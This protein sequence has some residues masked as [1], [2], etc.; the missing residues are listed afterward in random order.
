MTPRNAMA[1]ALYPHLAADRLVP[2]EQP[3]QRSALAEAM[4]PSLAPKPPPRSNPLRDSLLRNLRE[5]ND[6]HRG[7]K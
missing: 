1:A 4:Y 3:R 2:R 5:I 7:H 6:R